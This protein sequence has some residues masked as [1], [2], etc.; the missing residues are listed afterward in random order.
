[1]SSRLTTV[2]P[3]KRSSQL[4]SRCL[5]SHALRDIAVSPALSCRSPHWRHSAGLFTPEA[6]TWAARVSSALSLGGT[7]Y[8]SSICCVCSEVSLFK[9]SEGPSGAFREST[10]RPRPTL[11]K[12]APAGSLLSR[13]GGP[14]V[15]SVAMDPFGAGHEV[16]TGGPGAQPG[17]KKGKNRGRRRNK[18]R[19]AFDWKKAKTA[20]WRSST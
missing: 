12:G 11:K 18:K 17:G 5:A 4:V 1:M 10:A 8:P 14:Q 7:S 15:S 13:Q 19:A 16:C 3:G 20:A 9:F 6:A 2:I